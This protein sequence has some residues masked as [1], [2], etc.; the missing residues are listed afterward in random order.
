MGKPP[1]TQGQLRLAKPLTRDSPPC[2]DV[3]GE[4]QWPGSEEGVQEPGPQA[5]LIPLASLSSSPCETSLMSSFTD[6]ET[7]AS[8]CQLT[9]W[10]SSQNENSW[11][12]QNARSLRGGRGGL[13]DKEEH[14]HGRR[15][16]PS[17]P[18][19]QSPGSLGMPGLKQGPHC[20]GE[21]AKRQR[22]E[23]RQQGPRRPECGWLTQGS[24]QAAEEP[25]VR[26]R[27]LGAQACLHPLATVSSDPQ[28]LSHQATG[29]A[30]PPPAEAS[31]NKCHG[32]PTCPERESEC[33]CFLWSPPGSSRSLTVHP[34]S[35][36]PGGDAAQTLV[37]SQGRPGHQEVP[38]WH[39]L[40]N[41]MWQ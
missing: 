15:V 27:S 10:D 26:P 37:P 17:F 35:P 12:S 7:E 14:G 24:T 32:S 5:A 6:V 30:V 16:L 20:R 8:R 9:V 2:L 13:G 25:G 1:P 4:Q 29:N 39:G 22:P 31:Q 28:P 3:R 18:A 11:S 38:G 19:S 21:R 33:S 41:P 40:T 23:H 34:A 36:T